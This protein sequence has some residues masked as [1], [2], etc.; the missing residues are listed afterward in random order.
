[1]IGTIGFRFKL[2]EF[3]KV[4]SKLGVPLTVLDQ[5]YLFYRS[6]L[7]LIHLHLNIVVVLC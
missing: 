5:R 6:C 4:Q 7:F 3:S 1:M 2:Y